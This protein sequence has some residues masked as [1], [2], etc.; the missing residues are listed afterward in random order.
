[1][2]WISEGAHKRVFQIVVE[3]KLLGLGMCVLSYV[4]RCK[5]FSFIV[6]EDNFK[7][8]CSFETTI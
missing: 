6:L 3:S 2:E 1:M 7:N 5:V 4:T 8:I